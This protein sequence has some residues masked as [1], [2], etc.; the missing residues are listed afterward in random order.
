MEPHY[1]V[2]L[3]GRFDEWGL[4]YRTTVHEVIEHVQA[5][6][7]YVRLGIRHLPYGQEACLVV[8][9]RSFQLAEEEVVRIWILT[10]N[11]QDSGYS[12]TRP[13]GASN[14]DDDVRGIWDQAP[15]SSTADVDLRRVLL[16]ELKR[17]FARHRAARVAP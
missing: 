10:Y 7:D 8:W 4:H 17:P 14:R 1:R 12:V 11:A 5:S 13:Y 16:V 3:K 2:L 6:I 15:E 9:S